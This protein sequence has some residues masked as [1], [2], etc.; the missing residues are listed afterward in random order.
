MDIY[1][2]RS[3]WKAILAILAAILLLITTLYS[4]YL[5]NRLKENEEKNISLYT[6]A[7]ED[8]LNPANLSG[9]HD[10]LQDD[11]T[12]QN[13]IMNAFPLPVIFEDENGEL[14]GYNWDE[15]KNEDKAFLAHQKA[16]FLSDGMKPIKGTGYMNNIYCFNSPLLNYIKYYPLIQ[17]FLVGLFILM[18]YFAFSA[19]RKAEQNRVWAGMAKETAHQLGTPISAIMA[20][21]MHLKE[22]TK[23]EEQKEIIYE[24][25]RDV[26]RLEL[27]AD[28]FSKIGSAPE[29]EEVNLYDEL[30]EVKEYMQRRAPKKIEFVFPKTED[31]IR[32]NINKHLFD[33]VI[34]NLIRNSLD[35]MPGTGTIKAEVYLDGEYA[36]VDLTDD[37]KGIP[38]SKFKTVFQPGY[39]TKKRGWGLGLSLAK[40][41]IEN[42]H[43]GKIFV[44]SSKP[45]EGTTFTIKLP[46]LR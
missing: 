25:E 35:A 36:A 5:A 39:S 16:L 22:G 13:S 41:I 1:Q 29:L 30:Q 6:Q 32:V 7:L 19:S 45:D 3:R 42:Y 17:F 9:S 12:L 23:D 2:Q 44:K 20:W 14:T 24:L 4:N 15:S 28:R 18:G 11:V 10:A 34:E 46:L 33:W 26:E 43:N 40:R 27:V 31:Q 37:G 8:L 38:S 21:I